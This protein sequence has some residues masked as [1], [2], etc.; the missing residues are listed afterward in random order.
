MGFESEDAVAG[1]DQMKRSEIALEMD[2]K[3]ILEETSRYKVPKLLFPV[4]GGFETSMAHRDRLRTPGSWN[5]LTASE[6]W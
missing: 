6:A 2:E 3:Q 4:V 1:T 5:W